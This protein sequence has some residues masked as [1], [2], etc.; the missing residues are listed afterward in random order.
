MQVRAGAT[1]RNFA[2]PSISDQRLASTLGR[3]SRVC[4]AQPVSFRRRNPL[5]RRFG[6]VCTRLASLRTYTFEAQVVCLILGH[7]MG[8]PSGRRLAP[9]SRESGLVALLR[10]RIHEGLLR[11]FRP[12]LP[13]LTSRCTSSTGSPKSPSETR[14]IEAPGHSSKGSLA[15]P[16]RLAATDAHRSTE[17]VPICR[18]SG[19]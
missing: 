11:P 5:C 15:G 18:I 17:F 14:D 4:S 16:N 1:R 12:E 2:R 7:P 13:Q 3:M 10:C 6:R 9:Q 19:H 8:P